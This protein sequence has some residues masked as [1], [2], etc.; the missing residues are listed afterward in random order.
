MDI[1]SPLPSTDPRAFTPSAKSCT[2]Q[3]ALPHSFY[4]SGA[5]APPSA[6][7]ATFWDLSPLGPQLAPSPS[8]PN[9]SGQDLLNPRLRNKAA[10]VPAQMLPL[11][12]EV[13]WGC[14]M[15]P[16]S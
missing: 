7:W 3:L 14:D 11:L 6:A 5:T 13:T 2:H 10:P 1:S 12:T 9:Y 15:G 8:G 16:M 4:L